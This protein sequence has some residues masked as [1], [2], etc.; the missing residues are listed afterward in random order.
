MAG[1]VGTSQIKE[2]NIPKIIVMHPKMLPKIAIWVGL[3]AQVLAIALGIINK[4]FISN[5]P[6]NRIVIAKIREIS[7]VNIHLI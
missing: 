6:T 5:T 3:F 1:P 2:A 7:K 4:A